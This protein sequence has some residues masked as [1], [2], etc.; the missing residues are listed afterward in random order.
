MSYMKNKPIWI[1]IVLTVLIAAAI[2]GI[3]FFIYNRSAEDMMSVSD[4]EISFSNIELTDT[5][6]TAVAAFTASGKSYRKYN[7]TVEGNT[8]YITVYG[9][10]VSSRY[11]NGDFMIDIHDNLQ[12]ITTVCLKDNNN[13]TVL[14]TR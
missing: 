14:Y 2:A 6:L 1:I 5:N 10:L 8:L 12:N 11:P 7:Y 3:V 4:T 13:A 9:G